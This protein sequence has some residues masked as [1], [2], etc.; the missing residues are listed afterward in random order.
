[1]Q[2]LKAELAVSFIEISSINSYSEHS[3]ASSPEAET[4]SRTGNT[5]VSYWQ[6]Q[7]LFNDGV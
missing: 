3:K 5:P 1:M 6:L 2:S 4:S 7:L